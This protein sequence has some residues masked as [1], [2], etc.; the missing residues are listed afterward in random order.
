MRACFFGTYNSRH[1]SNRLL[2]RDL[3]AAGIE[4]HECHRPLWE[5]T[6]DKTARFFGAPSLAR[7]LPRYLRLA[8]SLISE[9]KRAGPFDLFLAGFNGQLD[10]LI[11]RGLTRGRTP[12]VFAPL[13][14]ITETLVEDRALFA[15]R[16][17]R[18]R[19]ARLLDRLTLEAADV[20]VADTMAHKAYFAQALGVDGQKIAVHYLGADEI[21][22]SPAGAA[23]GAS[24]VKVVLFYGQY[25]PLHGADVIVEAAARMARRSDVCFHF[26]GTG[27]ERPEAEGRARALGARIEFE[28]WVDFSKLP[29]RVAQASICLGAFGEGRKADMVIPTKV[30]Q[31]AAAGKVVVTGNTAAVRE[32]FR[33]GEEIALCRPG[34]P[35]ELARTLECLLGDPELS[36]KLGQG[37]GRLMER[38]F[39]SG[40]QA[41]SLVRELS[42]ASPKLARSLG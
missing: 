23:S 15:A 6:R 11:L 34:D 36:R 39:S 37:A 3:E 29:A 7:H 9:V 13:M 14:S 40:E 28:D 17:V 8:A 25:V 5:R 2:I 32:V 27:P 4:V 38:R 33:E 19:L 26:I 35:A 16:S 22:F 30:Y 24:Q 20:V 10:V 41:K 21:F 31:A 42:A 12:I 1:P 18:G